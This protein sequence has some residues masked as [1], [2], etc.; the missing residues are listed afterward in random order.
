LGNRGSVNLRIGITSISGALG[1]LIADKSWSFPESVLRLLTIAYNNSQR[2][3]RLVNDIL[4]IEKIMSGRLVFVRKHVE[5]R[6]LAEQ[7]IEANRGF[8]DVYGVHVHLDRNC[9]NGVL[10]SD[11]DRLF[12]VVNN[13]LS[14]A[15]KA[16]PSG[17]EVVVAIEDLAGVARLSVRDH[18]SGIPGEFRLRVFEK[19][20]QFDNS[21]ARQKGGTGLGLSIVRQIVTRL[22]G[23]VAF[24]DAPGGGTI[25]HVDLPVG[26]VGVTGAG[27]T[28]KPQLKIE[29]DSRGFGI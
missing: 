27:Y 26:P 10:Q 17:N 19:F 29:I 21:D 7:A 14:N 2:L 18:G 12:Q 6:L 28:T 4:D 24:N 20:A 8:A 11:P 16:S 3:T 23:E 22:G 13:L 9:S 15:I 5:L 1:L 25:F